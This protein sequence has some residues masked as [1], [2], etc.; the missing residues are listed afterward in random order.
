MTLRI[1]REAGWRSPAV[2][3]LEGSIAAEWAE[4]LEHVCSHFLRVTREDLRKGVILN[5][6]AVNFVDR[7]GIGVLQR[8]AQKGAVIVCPAGP[9]ASVLEGEGIPLIDPR[10]RSA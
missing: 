1:T 7:A 9:V 10:R 2:L 5:L 8:L 6:T 3:R 4:L